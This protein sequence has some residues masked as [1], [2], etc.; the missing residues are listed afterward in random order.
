MR[1]ITQYSSIL[2]IVFVLAIASASGQTA[3]PGDSPGAAP[4]GSPQ[5]VNAQQSGAW[6]VGIDPAKN[7][8][9]LASTPSDPLAVKL[10]NSGS[11]RKPFQFRMIVAPTGIGNS[12]AYYEIPAGKRLVIENVSAVARMPEGMKAE[13]NFYCHLDNGDGIGDVADISFHRIALTDQGYISPYQIASANHK[14]L[15]FA[16]G[17]IGTTQFG[18]TV[19]ARLS[20]TAA[21]GA[22]QV[23]L[24]FSGYIEDVPTP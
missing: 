7:T 5:T 8:V 14:V 12:S 1:L 11:A 15:V 4:S 3:R 13:V 6:T 20:G 16:D 24:T 19:Q 9:K 18:L 17:L 21:P 22:A 23:Q 10:V 2:L